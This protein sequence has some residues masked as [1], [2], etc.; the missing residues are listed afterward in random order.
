MLAGMQPSFPPF[1]MKLE[2]INQD[3][4]GFSSHLLSDTHTRSHTGSRYTHLHKER[5]NVFLILTQGRLRISLA[6]K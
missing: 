5:G 6:I 3:L 2:V 4:C 1:E